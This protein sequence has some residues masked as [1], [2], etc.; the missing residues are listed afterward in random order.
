M[1]VNGP[2][3]TALADRF[4]LLGHP[5]RLQILDVLRRS[6]ECVC[7]LEAL[8]DKPQPYISQQLRILREAGVIVDRREGL[9][10]FYHLVDPQVVALLDLAI[11]PAQLSEPTGRHVVLTDCVCPKCSEAARQAD[12]P[13]DG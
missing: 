10:V 5:V 9:N 11:G 3:Y 2:E 7:H 1:N 13:T 6:P 8:L 12:H 4:K